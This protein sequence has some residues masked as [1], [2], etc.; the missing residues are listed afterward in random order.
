M[1]RR[2]KFKRLKQKAK[3]AAMHG[4][5]NPPVPNQPSKASFRIETSRKAW[6][7]SRLLSQVFPLAFLIASSFGANML[8]DIS[9]ILGYLLLVTSFSIVFGHW[10]WKIVGWVG[11]Y[12]KKSHLIQ[13]L[14]TS[15]VVLTTF[16]TSPYYKDFFI[17]STSSI[18]MPTFVN[19]STQ[20]LV[21]Y[22]SGEQAFWTQTTIGELKKGKQVP[23]RINDKEIFVVHVEQNKLYIDTMLFAGFHNQSQHIFSKP[24]E[25]RNNAFSRQPEGWKIYQNN[26]NLEIVNEA[27]IPVLL[28]QYESPYNITISGLFVTPMGI[29]KVDNH[30]GAGYVLGDS[31]SELGE[32]RVNRVFI[33]SIIDL[34]RS[35]RTYVLK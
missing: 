3:P 17:K 26:M 13:I 6:W 29:C 2:N 16:I 28:M 10:T 22:G 31:L 30:D 27:G 12:S 5:V 7:E 18:E 25:I 15:L 19:D 33:H 20:I 11:K 4:A 23:L 9:P 21:H 1:P 35:E 14:L 34:F 8:N 32:Y 24:V